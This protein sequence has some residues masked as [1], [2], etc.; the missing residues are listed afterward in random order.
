MAT[1]RMAAIFTLCLTAAPLAMAQEGV[2][3][4]ATEPSQQSLADFY[5]G[6]QLNLLVG[7]A[8]GG[9]YDLYARHVAR[10]FARHL[11]GS[12]NIV[13]QNMPG[14][15]GLVLANHLATRAPRDGT[16]FG[17]IH[18][19]LT[20]RQIAG[21][22][23]VRYDMREFGWLGSANNS[24][25]VCVFS[26]RVKAASAKDLLAREII[27]GGSGGST[28]YVPAFLNS[29]LGTQFKVVAG[30]KS[31]GDV[32]IAI[33]RGEVDGLC[34]W[35]WDSAKASASGMLDRGVLKVGLQ[36]GVEPHPE[37]TAMGVPYVMDIARDEESRALLEFA[38]G[39]LVYIRPFVTPPE[40]PAER[41]KALQAAFAATMKDEAFL[42]EAK[43]N[44]VEIRF[45]DPQTV[46]KA[47]EAAFNAP[48]K[49]KKLAIQR[50]R[51]AGLGG[52]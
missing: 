24:S 35:G 12:P 22:K 41:L 51:E 28:T 9:G 27:V 5:G 34:G 30:Y 18:G 20:I 1:G 15:G 38:F 42:A 7:S 52:L 43:K 14:A 4:A 21:A 49:V 10:H 44:D 33:E 11:P 8:P 25:N 23:N 46:R 19:P 26:P 31:T 47:M 16:V 3:K 37:L 48:E 45:A 2:G 6:N 50:L 40:L 39:Y 17:H 29:V 13:V 36:V 32:A